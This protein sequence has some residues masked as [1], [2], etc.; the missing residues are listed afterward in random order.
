MTLTVDSASQT[1]L[2]KRITQP[3]YLISLELDTTRH[4]STRGDVSWN[5]ITW[6]G[7]LV[8]LKSAQ[9][10]ST[11]SLEFIDLDFHLQQYLS[12]GYWRGQS[13]AV[14]LY[15]PDTSDAVELFAGVLTAATLGARVQLSAQRSGVKTRWTPTVRLEAPLCN[16]LVAPGTTVTWDGQVYEIVGQ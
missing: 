14:Y 4:L 2:A 15:I 7:A 3:C 11:V 9:D 1:A 12:G 10:W 5:S 8:A 13:C 6:S 16:H